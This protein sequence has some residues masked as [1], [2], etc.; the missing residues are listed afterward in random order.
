MIIVFQERYMFTNSA[1]VA[2]EA[3]HTYMELVGR[4]V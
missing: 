1:Q 3:M 4:T 2:L